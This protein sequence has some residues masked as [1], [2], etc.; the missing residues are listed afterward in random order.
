[1]VSTPDHHTYTYVSSDGGS[2]VISYDWICFGSDTAY[3]PLNDLVCTSYNDAFSNTSTDVFVQKGAARRSIT[4]PAERQTNAARRNAFLAA[5][6]ETSGND[7]Y[8]D[9]RRFSPDAMA[10]GEARVAE[11]K[12]VTSEVSPAFQKDHVVT[13]HLPDR[14]GRRVRAAKGGAERSVARHGAVPASDHDRRIERLG[15]RRADARD[16]PDRLH[17]RSPRLDDRRPCRLR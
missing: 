17:Q 9:V 14:M 12:P 7:L 8:L 6:T 13:R 5:W 10:I 2:P 15:R 11:S 16:M 1:M 3:D 4:A